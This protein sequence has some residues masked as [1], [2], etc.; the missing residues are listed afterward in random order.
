MAE[1]SAK[2]GPNNLS[3]IS[4]R[5]QEAQLCATITEEIRRDYPA[6][7]FREFDDK[8]GI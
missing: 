1:A 2:L 4:L 8:E 6:A 5:N 3:I 7:K